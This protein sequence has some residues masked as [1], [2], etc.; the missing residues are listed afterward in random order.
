MVSDAPIPKLRP[1]YILVKVHCIALN[2][3]DWKAVDNNASKGAICGCD[4]SGVVEE[5]GKDV[6]K[7][8]KKG[9]RVCGMAHG[10]NALNHE[11]GAF[12]EYIVAKGDV[13][14]HVPDKMSFEDAA[15]WGVGIATVGQAMYQALELPLPTS[16]SKEAFPVLIYGGSTATGTL[17]IQFAKL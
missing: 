2:P 17:A 12:A 6:T 9:D 8:F 7:S 5:V 4:Y 16:P 11:D 1:E 14:M 15:T 13:Q 10:S 3:T